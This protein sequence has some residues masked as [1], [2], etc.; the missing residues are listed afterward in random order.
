MIK[1][2]TPHAHAQGVKVHRIE[3]LLP[4]ILL[5]A[6]VAS[7]KIWNTQISDLRKAA[8]FFHA[9]KPEAIT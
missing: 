5:Y 9:A 4:V 6:S 3:I 1:I 7:E 8:G 2:R